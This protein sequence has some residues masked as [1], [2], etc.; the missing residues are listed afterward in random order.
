MDFE[1][2]YYCLMPSMQFILDERGSILDVNHFGA[3]SLGY[4]QDELIGASILKTVYEMDRSYV[5]QQM[6]KVFNECAH[7]IHQI[8]YRK[9]KKDGSIIWVQEYL[10]CIHQEDGQ[11]ILLIS[12]QDISK[13]KRTEQLLLGQKK[14]LE[15]IAKGK[16]I[17]EILNELIITIEQIN[18]MAIGS[19]LVLD[20]K[21]NRL[22]HAAS[23]H[24]PSEYIQ[25]TNGIQIG[26]KAGSCGTAAYRKEI[27][28]VSDI[29]RDPL[30][31]D[32]K[33][34]A[35]A[36]GLRS[37]WA[38][39]IFSST[40]QVL[41]TFAIYHY[42]SVAPTKEDLEII[43]T[44]SSLAGLAI[45]QARMREKLEKNQQRYQSLF[46]Y[47]HDGVFSLD[48]DGKFLSVNETAEK[49]S[50]YSQTE[51]AQLHFSKLV[52]HEDVK[53]AED[54]FEQAKRGT[55]QH[56]RIRIYN[57]Q[58]NL[59]YLNVTTVPI[60]VNG[61]V[62]GVFGIAKNITESIEAEQK[63]KYM[64]YYDSLTG[65]A[66]RRLFQERVQ[67]TIDKAKMKK[68]LFA[69]LYIDFDRFKY[70]NDSLGHSA[71]D[72]LLKKAARRLRRCVYTNDTV[73]RMGGDEFIILLPKISTKKDAIETAKQIL[74]SFQKPIVVH[75][76]EL[77]LTPSIGISFYPDDGEDAEILI[78]HADLAMFEAKQRGKNGYF[79]YCDHQ[80]QQMRTNM[81][82]LND[83]QKAIQQKELFL[84]YQPIVKL[85]SKQIVAVEAL[86]RWH[87]PSLGAIPPNTFIPLAEES[88]LIVQLGEWVLK[89][90]CRQAKQWQKEGLAP[91]R[92]CVNIS[93]R[94]LQ[95]RKYAKRVEMIL[96]EANL[97]AK[98][99]E[100]EITERMMVYNEP[101]ITRNLN[102][103]KQLGVRIAVDDFGT[104]CSSLSYL[105]QLDIDTLKI[106]RSF[107]QECPHS[108]YEKA[109]V[110]SVLSLVQHL[111]MNVIAEGIEDEKQF[112]YLAKNG[113][114]EGQ[115]YFFSPPLSAEQLKQMLQ[116][117]NEPRHV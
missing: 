11:Q 80:L 81:Q 74:C 41:G 96:Q 4:T 73:A 7:V 52:V 110:D 50:G 77:F 24:L 61:L 43:E 71:G 105:K 12:C 91:I 87:H 99:L 90:A 22:Y 66:N 94:E 56:A 59:L 68:Q 2:D 16:E 102:L 57:K 103:L 95:D 1:R 51:L 35:L 33:Q 10:R 20:K 72:L 21:E 113:C 30:W 40:E 112:D 69:I 55:S 82:L 79:V 108:Y 63:I 107:I 65:V 117:M 114:S 78:K 106:D 98:W 42:N 17:N 9:Q 83:L 109:I 29:E 31:E 97:E 116:N 76:H 5:E 23:P 93:A 86:V 27:V 89:E 47:N 3:K 18:P 48:L 49:I 25:A 70:V 60:I 26:E 39:P 115:G 28:I 13:Q 37:C 32:Y 92:V 45:E 88:G 111:N 67:E 44:F 8:S 85:S 54:L 34:I 84:L 14:I 101:T 53:V 6:N 100:L 19:I 38:I 62:T 46:K 58:R 15:M 104:G 64:A 36:H 75:G